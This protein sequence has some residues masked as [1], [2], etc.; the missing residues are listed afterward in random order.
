MARNG[1]RCASCYVVAQTDLSRVHSFS[2]HIQ[3]YKVSHFLSRGYIVPKERRKGCD[4]EVFYFEIGSVKNSV[5]VP[6]NGI[7]M[8]NMQRCVPRIQIVLEDI[9]C[10]K[11]VSLFISSMQRNV[12]RTVSLELV[13]I[14]MMH[15][16]VSDV[17]SIE[18]I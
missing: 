3:S 13:R 16:L 17:V 7:S 6:N 10:S 11:H 5:Q 12:Y 18:Y 15:R 2:V 4:V 8:T 1:C 9:S 14:N